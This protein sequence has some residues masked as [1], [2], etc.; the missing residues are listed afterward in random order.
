MQPTKQIKWLKIEDI[1]N[2]HHKYEKFK[3]SEVF[4]ISHM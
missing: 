2:R 4:V 3:S 1:F